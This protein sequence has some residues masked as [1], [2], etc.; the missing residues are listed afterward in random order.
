MSNYQSYLEESLSKLRTVLDDSGTRP[1]LF[2]GSGLSRRY[3]GAPDWV[4]LLT[5]LIEINPIIKMPIGYYTQNTNN[6]LPA[7]ASALV[8]KYQTYAWE[9]YEEEIFPAELYNHSYAKSIFLKSQIAQILDKLMESFNLEDNEYYEELKILK[10]LNPHAVI[11][12]NYDRLLE[13][14]F[15]KFKVVIGQQV[16]KKKEA[17]SIGH[18]LKIHG[19]T[20]KPEE[21]VISAED[22]DSFHEKQKYLIAKLLTYFMEHPVIFLGYSVADEN[23]KNILADISEMVSGGSNE[24]VNNIWFVEWEKELSLIK[25]SEPTRPR[26]IS[27]AAFCLKKK[28]YMIDLALI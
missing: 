21:I 28:K 18:I 25:I 13:T 23:I 15:D 5:K 9:K 7:V 27:N 6:H 26:R 16:I 20:E 2:I 1:I 12:T 14:I 8:E 11:T 24:I 17:T 10:T 4:G 19:S 3:V 22:Y